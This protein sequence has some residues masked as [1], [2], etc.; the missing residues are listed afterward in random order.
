MK[1]SKIL[2]PNFKSLV[3]YGYMTNTT[4]ATAGKKGRKATVI[5]WPVT[6]FTIKDM[7]NLNLGISN[8]AIQL[9]VNKAVEAG[10]LA[11]S[12]KICSG[13]GRPKTVYTATT[14]P[15]VAQSFI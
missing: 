7:E 2:L 5:N 8:V 1:F 13:K 6:P 4:Q 12:G 11:I 15:V 3:V 14:A 9:K 10:V